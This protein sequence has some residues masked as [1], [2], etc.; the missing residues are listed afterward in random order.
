MDLTH[1]DK[2]SVKEGWFL[3][4]TWEVRMGKGQGE[5]SQKREWFRM[6]SVIQVKVSDICSCRLVPVAGWDLCKC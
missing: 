1:V 5:A 4:G 6:E 3:R 2:L